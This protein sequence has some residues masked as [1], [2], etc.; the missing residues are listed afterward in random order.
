MCMV[1]EDAY[2][3]DGILTRHDGDAEVISL[4]DMPFFLT[5]LCLMPEHD[6]VAFRSHLHHP[7]RAGHRARR[8]CG[9]THNVPPLGR[10]RRRQSRG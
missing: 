9:A 8:A 3:S 2:G 4:S 10:Q 7:G 5:C 1:R 6:L